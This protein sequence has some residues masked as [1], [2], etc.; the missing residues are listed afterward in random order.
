[1][2]NR[3]WLR[4]IRVRKHIVIG[5]LVVVC[6]ATLFATILAWLDGFASLAFLAYY[7]LLLVNVL[8]LISISNKEK[9]V[10]RN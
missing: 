10:K 1:M 4:I 6:L 3:N 7:P 5:C 8:I 9:A 2:K